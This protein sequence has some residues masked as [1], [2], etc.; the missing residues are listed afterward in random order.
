MDDLWDAQAAS[1]AAAILYRRMNNS[2]SSIPS[3]SSSPPLEFKSPALNSLS[4]SRLLR[5]TVQ[6]QDGAGSVR[7]YLSINEIASVTLPNHIIAIIDTIVELNDDAP[8]IL[9]NM[10]LP[11]PTD[12]YRR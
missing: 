6:A 4:L 2:L 12:T 3:S 8:C 7:R 1:A 9:H 10:V 11:I 5:Q